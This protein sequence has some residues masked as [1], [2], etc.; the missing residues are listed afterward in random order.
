MSARKIIV[1]GLGPG[2][3]GQLTLA[4]FKTIEAA[5]V[6]YL[7]TAKHPTVPHLPP[8]PRHEAFDDVYDRAAT[9]GEVYDTIVGQLLDLAGR[10]DEAGPVVYAVP[11]HP[12]VGEASVLRLLARAS[13]AGVPVEIVDG[14]SFLEP[15]LSALQLD[16]LAQGLVILDATELAERVEPA[17]PREHGLELPVTRPLL[18]GQVYNQRLAGAVKLALM[19]NYPDEHPVT[20]LRGAG[21]PG[22][23]MRLDIPLFEL[24]RHP[25]W[26]DH[27]TCAYLPPLPILAAT[28]TWPNAHYLVALL[29]AEGGCEWDRRQTHASL[30]RH[31]LEEAY[32]VL[33]ALD[34]DPD[35]LAEEMGDLLLQILLHA[36]IA[37]EAGEWGIGDVLGELSAKL[38]RRHPHI[39]G[40]ATSRPDWEEIKRA[41]RDPS[42]SVLAGVPAAMPALQQAQA[43]QRK[44][45][46]IGFE[47]PNFEAVLEKLVEEIEEV[48]RA[49]NRAEQIDELG[50]VLA[51]LANAA[52]WLDIDAEEALRLANSKFR[53][54]FEQ[55]EILVRGRQLEPKTMSPADLQ[56]LWQEAKSLA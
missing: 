4:A 35:H 27:L 50:D 24:D 30:K 21:V 52:R 44:A 43:L 49:S 1:V 16:P 31:L 39:F 7:R 28:G 42:V 51:V 9:F 3:P 41:E 46:A 33:H 2:D 15:C 45:G 32:E 23:A 25:E 36:Q 12:L 20:L 8:G 54:R 55:W 10:Q 26:T 19:E 40:G 5:R 29:R 56:A 37:A 6:L 47:W 18:I 22:E 13:A 53:R 11:G 17:R 48:R 38:I 14:L 34:E